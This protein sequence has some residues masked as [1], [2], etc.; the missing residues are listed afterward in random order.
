MP[1]ALS[2][3]LGFPASAPSVSSS[4]RPSPTGRE[5]ARR[6]TCWGPP[7]SC[8][9]RTGSCMQDAGI[10]L[11]PSNDFSL[12]DQVL[13]TVALVGAVPARYGWDGA[14]RRPRHLL[15]D[16]PRPPDRRRRRDRDGDDEVVRHQLPLHRPRARAAARSSRFARASR[17]T[18]YAEAMRSWASRPCR[19]WSGRSPSCC[20]ASRR[21]RPR[22]STASSCSS[23]ARGL[24]GGARAARQGRRASGCSSTSPCF[25]ED[26][27]PSG[28]RRAR[29]RLRGARHASHERPQIVV[30]TYF[31]HVGEA[32]AVLRDLPSAGVGARL[33]RTGRTTVELV[34]KHGLAGGQDAVRR[35]RRRP[36]RLDQR[37]R[38]AASTC[39]RSCASTRATSSS[40]RPPARCCTRR[41][42]ST[43][44]RRPRRRAALLDGVR[45]AEG[46]RGGDADA[47]GLNEGRDAI[48]GGARRERR[49]RSR[50]GATRRARATRGAR[51]RSRR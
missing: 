21:R 33:R 19:S 15:R 20:R 4:S 11:I 18:S 27:M 16:G 7:R 24:R 13:D 47:R 51:A 45:D 5:T 41:S 1:Q 2:N 3:V 37:P 26:R 36:Q 12:Y 43:P 28:A 6:R 10:D 40:S 50:T 48:V 44:S 25:V 30:K 39:S 14:R 23:P 34:A 42:T 31:D 22:T 9:R 35:H 46:R 17:S 49:R 38:R 32:Y 8:A 29:A